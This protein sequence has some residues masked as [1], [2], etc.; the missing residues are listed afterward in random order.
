MRRRFRLR[1]AIALP[2]LGGVLGLA[3]LLPVPTT[4]DASLQSVVN[5][6]EARLPGWHVARATAAW[7]GAYSVVATCGGRELGFQL[8]PSHGL[9][10]GDVWIQPDDRYAQ[11]RLQEV[12]DHD[13]YL[14]WYQMPSP[15]RTLSCGAELARSY[16]GT[17]PGTDAQA[18]V[19]T[20]R[21]A[22]GAAR[23]HD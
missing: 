5:E 4:G 12:S 16:P 8:V 17:R 22:A 14:V 21:T 13:V 3:L 23:P 18:E 20:S 9:P 6:V 1:R 2:L 19:P 10:V 7:E 11:S 15:D